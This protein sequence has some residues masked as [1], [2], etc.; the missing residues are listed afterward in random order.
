[1]TIPDN[2]KRYD[3]FEDKYFQF[4]FVYDSNRD[5]VWKEVCMYLQ[6]K[7]I[8]A[9]S[10]ILDLGAGY[11]NFI[12]NIHGKEKHAVDLFS[13]LKEF[14]NPEVVSHIRPCT[15]L[16]FLDDSFFDIVFAS[17]LFEHL[18]REDLLK[19]LEEIWRITKNG[20]KLICIQPNFKFCYKGYF[21]DYTH[22]QIFTHRSMSELIETYGFNISIIKPKFLPMSMKT[23]LKFNLPFLHLIVRLYLRLPVRPLAAQMLII[24]EKPRSVATNN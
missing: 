18:T 9:N 14:S 7:Y 8:P 15:D 13:R 20:G 22:L 12:N 5:R 17:N 3:I 21:D 1:M 10:R 2:N 4:N 24:A 23:T 19:A 11:C 16:D 6:N